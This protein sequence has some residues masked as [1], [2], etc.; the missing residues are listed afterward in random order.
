VNHD[1]FLDVVVTS[2]GMFK[3]YLH[4]GS[5]ATPF[6][7]RTTLLIQFAAR[8]KIGD[9]DRDSYLDI[10]VLADNSLLYLRNS[11]PSSNYDFGL[12]T[13]T[14]VFT[15][16]TFLNTAVD[17][18]QLDSSQFLSIVSQPNLISMLASSL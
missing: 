5:R 1:G 2:S 6:I 8:V 15:S 13:P 14:Q 11:G 12:V 4:P 9:Y 10:L 3:V 18:G 7:L 16:P 17:Y